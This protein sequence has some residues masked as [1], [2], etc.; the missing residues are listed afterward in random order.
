MHVDL[1]VTR[2]QVD[3]AKIVPLDVPGVGTIEVK[4]DPIMD[5]G[6]QIR[7]HGRSPDGGD[8]YAHIKIH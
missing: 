1:F 3:S 5:E 2:S 6:M 7:M 4:L 8:V